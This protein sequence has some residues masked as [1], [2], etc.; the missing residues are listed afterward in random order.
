MSCP[1]S[2]TR[3]LLWLYGEGD[4]AH[5]AHIASCEACQEVVALHEGVVSA[6]A[7]IA[8]AL[9]RTPPKRWTRP[10]VY[11]SLLLAAAALFVTVVGAQVGQ[12]TL[13]TETA[14]AQTGASP[15]VAL[16]FDDVLDEDLDEID[17]ALDELSNDLHTL[18]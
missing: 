6:T 10:A 7:P 4:D 8:P 16:S 17:A 2:E 15:T 14:V 13:P 9:R 3:T 5:A 1:H 11:G 12:S 18:L